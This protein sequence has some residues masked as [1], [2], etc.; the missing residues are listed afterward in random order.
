MM[1]EIKL[2]VAGEDKFENGVKQKSSIFL[3]VKTLIHGTQ[4]DNCAIENLSTSRKFS[5]PSLIEEIKPVI[6]VKYEFEYREKLKFRG[7]L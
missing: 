6:L 4:I 5:M 3:T 2:V 7:F 1:E